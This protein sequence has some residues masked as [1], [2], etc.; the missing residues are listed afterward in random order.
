MSQSGRKVNDT[1]WSDLRTGDSLCN[2][3]SGGMETAVEEGILMAVVG[4][5]LTG[6]RSSTQSRAE[7]RI[8]L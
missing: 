3:T 5:T 2:R 7:G 6:L 1:R 4:K 8:V